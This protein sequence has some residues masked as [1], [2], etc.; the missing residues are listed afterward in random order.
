MGK[1]FFMCSFFEH[2][3]DLPDPR[4][5]RTKQH[6]LSDILF[7]TIAAVLSGC[8]DW[9]AIELYGETKEE[10]LRKYLELPNGIPSHDTFNRLFAALD[11]TA[12][13]ECFLSWVQ[14]VVSVTEGEVVSIDGKRLCASGEQ[15][16][17][18]LI[19]LVSAW[20][21]ANHMVLA[22]Y[23]V[24]DKSNEITAIPTLL[25][26]LE[27]K[28]CIVTIDAMGCQK[29][30]AS[31]IIDKEAD[32]IL[33]VKGNQPFLLDDIKEAFTENP[34]TSEDVQ[35]GVGHGRIERR[36]CRVLHDTDWICK[37]KEWKELKS[38]IEI[39]A[40]R[41]HKTSGEQQKEVRYYIS[42]LKA[43][44]A[45]FNNYIRSHWGIENHLHWTL[46]VV[47]SEDESRKRAGHAAENFA[48]ITRIALNLLKNDG[49]TKVSMKS[50]RHKAGWDN[51]YV[52]HLLTQ[53]KI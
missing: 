33:A 14:S 45:S 10:W 29:E 25:D 36:T 27:L 50:K 21:E 2:F 40:E 23:K 53:S 34:S 46:D 16:K 17:R 19:H 8:D 41:T 18:S 35:V 43:D 3:A 24:E 42:S 44:A 9:N 1:S 5:E 39:T 13:R 52:I 15:G 7:I 51:E 11:S 12:L 37:A 6:K 31:S 22:Q 28:S 47:F 20:S 48:L 49:S 38:L 4:L 32:Y 30:I 26:V